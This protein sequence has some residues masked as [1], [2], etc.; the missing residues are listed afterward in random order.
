MLFM[1]VKPNA[2]SLDTRFSVRFLREVR[3]L[4]AKVRAEF[5]EEESKRLRVAYTGRHAISTD[6]VA[7][8]SRDVVWIFSLSFVSVMALFLLAFRR[9][10]MLVVVGVPLLMGVFWTLGVTYF[11]LGRLNAVTSTVGAILLGLGIDY[12]IHIY[13]QYAAERT[14][15]RPVD[16]A[17]VA[18]LTGIGSGLF[19]AAL[20]TALAFF[21]TLGLGLPR[22]QVHAQPLRSSPSE[23][24]GEAKGGILPDRQS[25]GL[26]TPR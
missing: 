18:A 13:N 4:E 20:S 11:T 8:L 1:L 17:I 9:A 7:I 22:R 19:S 14:A 26:R 12:G 16:E 23:G 6:Y 15:G 25:R 5:P 3:A 10:G 2:S 21:A 24:P